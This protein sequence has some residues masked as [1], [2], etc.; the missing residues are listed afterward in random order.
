MSKRAA[1]YQ[2]VRAACAQT[3]PCCAHTN[4]RGA[5]GR[6]RH[7]LQHAAEVLRDAR[8]GGHHHAEPVVLLLVKA[9]GWVHA[10]LVQYA[11]RRQLWP[12]QVT[13]S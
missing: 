13:A 6:A 12:S 4:R 1:C 11:A 9:V 5:G 8:V 3:K 2:A 10:A 7:L